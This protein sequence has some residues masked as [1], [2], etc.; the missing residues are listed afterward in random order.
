[1]GTLQQHAFATHISAACMGHFIPL[2]TMAG[3]ADYM[4]SIT[5]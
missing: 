4:V 1:M 2:N 5:T 3:G